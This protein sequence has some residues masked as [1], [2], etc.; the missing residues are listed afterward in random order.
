MKLIP[1]HDQIMSE[2][3][4]STY[5]LLIAHLL[6]PHGT[7]LVGVIYR[8]PSSSV[9]TFVSEFESL[10]YPLTGVNLALCRIYYTLGAGGSSFDHRLDQAA[11]DISRTH[12]ACQKLH[13]H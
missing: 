11:S 13:P 12:S 7:M 5:E 4:K 1:V 6:C 3:P 2:L 8:P 9:S 10:L